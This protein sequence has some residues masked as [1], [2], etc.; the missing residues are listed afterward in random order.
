MM[1]RWVD[2][3]MDGLTWEDGRMG[4]WVTMDG[5]T[6]RWLNVGRT[7]EEVG[8]WKDG[9]VGDEW[10]GGWVSCWISTNADEA[11]RSGLSLDQEKVLFSSHEDWRPV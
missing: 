5:R 10:M 11:F 6:N 8:R 4:E 7:N 1:S 3:W 9:C 2:G